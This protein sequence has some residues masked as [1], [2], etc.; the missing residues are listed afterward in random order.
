MTSLGRIYKFKNDMLDENIGN[1]I[2]KVLETICS[3]NF[4]DLSNINIEFIFGQEIKSDLKMIADDYVHA[5]FNNF[6]DPLP[7]K[8]LKDASIELLFLLE[9]KYNAQYMQIVSV[10]TDKKLL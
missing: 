3:F 5:D 6:E 1:D 4:L 10:F 2:R 7:L 9:S 8:S